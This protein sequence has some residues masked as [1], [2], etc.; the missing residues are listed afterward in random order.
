MKTINSFK[1]AFKGGAITFSSQ[2]NFRFHVS[3]FIMVA[4]LGLLYKI[5]LSEWCIF[6]QSS[7]LVLIAEMFNTSLEYLC[8]FIT[9]EKKEEIRKVKDVAAGA[10]LIAALISLIIGVIIFLPRMFHF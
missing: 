6:L 1:N 7:G 10:V 9:K 4:V 8:D 3:V 5:N 2:R